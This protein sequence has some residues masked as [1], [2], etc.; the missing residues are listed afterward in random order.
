MLNLIEAKIQTIEQAQASLAARRVGGAKI[1]FTNGCFD[2]LHAGH[3]HY[4]AE[5]RALGQCLVV[6]LNS[7]ASV[8][9]LKGEHRPIKEETS[10]ALLLASLLF[11]DLV[12]IFSEDTP[13]QLINQ[14]KPDVLVKGGDYTEAT[15]VGAK[16][17]RSWGGDVQ[18]LS[19]LPGYSTSKLE[20]KIKAS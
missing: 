3:I 4:L 7:D 20:A 14:L 9:R 16:A 18:L 6:G 5:A 15:V 13:L 1:V 17:V 8:A 19:F 11:V 10:R 12:V 2:L